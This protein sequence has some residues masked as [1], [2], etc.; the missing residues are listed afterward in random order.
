[1]TVLR[2]LK[3]SFLFASTEKD[4]VACTLSLKMYSILAWHQS[5]IRTYSNVVKEKALN[6]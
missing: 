6:I 4:V 3:G 2:L 1:M 5:Q